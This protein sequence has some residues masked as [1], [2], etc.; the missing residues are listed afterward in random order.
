MLKNKHDSV[1][2]KNYLLSEAYKKLTN[3]EK[4]TVIRKRSRHQMAKKVGK[5]TKPWV[6]RI[7]YNNCTGQWVQSEEIPVLSGSSLNRKKVK[8]KPSPPAGPVMHKFSTRSK[9]K[10]R[11]KATAF[12][13]SIFKDRVFLTL[14]FI[15]DV[16]DRDGVK[17]LN[18]FLT[19]LRKD[20][21]KVEYCWFAQHQLKTTGRIHFHCIL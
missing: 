20:N 6:W 7:G 17:I 13:R 19:V 10:A 16:T 1:L 21:P 5:P 15:D 4:I 14:T 9:A 11:D 18:K 8:S 12:F 3:P 2:E